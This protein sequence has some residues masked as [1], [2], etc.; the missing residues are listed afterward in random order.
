MQQ[1]NLVSTS[2]LTYDRAPLP[3]ADRLL[4]LENKMQRSFVEIGLALQEIKDKGLYRLTHNS[5]DSYCQDRWNMASR[6]Y[7]VKLIKAA[8]LYKEFEAEGIKNLPRNEFQCR[9]LVES[10]LNP[11]EQ[12]A[13]W[14]ESV[15]RSP[16]NIPS[17][18]QVREVV[19][20]IMES[21][22]VVE[23][24]AECTI[25]SG[26]HQGKN[27][28]VDRVEGGAIVWVLLEGERDLFPCFL[29][30]LQPVGGPVTLPPPQ[31][32]K[33][34]PKRRLEETLATIAAVLED[35]Q[36]PPSARQRLEE[37]LK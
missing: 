20:Q 3:S 16:N 9:P 28:T 15:R 11:Q 26:M 6:Q 2:S 25:I 13:A 1:L 31:P 30:E 4:Q 18:K 27:C 5:F 12:R 33:P 35:E 21:R 22:A 10:D 29:A 7:A 32:P 36:L 23:V 14:Q 24:G 19:D 8:A 17:A 34:T 37:L